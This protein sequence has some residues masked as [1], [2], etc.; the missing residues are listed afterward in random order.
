MRLPSLN[1]LR[2]FEA[3]ARHNGYIAAA[4]ELFVTR[5]AISR[6][7]KLLEEHLGVKLFRRNHKGVELTAAGRELLPVLTESFRAVARQCE[8]IS[9]NAS[10]LRIIC[11]PALSIR[12]LFPIL[13][14]FREMHPEIRVRLT[15]DFYGEKGFDTSEYDLGIS[16]ENLP[17]RSPNIVTHPL[18]PSILSPACAPSLLEGGKS[19]S[20]PE[21]IVNF[22][23]LHESPR[24]E[25][26]ATWAHVFD[27][28]EIDPSSGEAFPNLD[29]ATKAAVM[30]SGII[31]ADL[32]LCREEIEQGTLVLPLGHMKCEEPY[33][34]Y[35]LIGPRDR[36]NDPKVRR[37][38]DWVVG[39]V[40]AD[41]LKRTSEVK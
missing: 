30:G 1:A 35:S 28:K 8:S 26:W 5:G 11:P 23:L 18:F 34:Q 2:A 12:W 25:D 3:A 21:D 31:M 24:R 33:G 14:Q 22:K 13:E 40:N 37:F 10:E 9:S 16:V 19:I 27:V 29:M 7:V 15:T 6:H 20:A 41:A 32:A 38:R 17:G 36:W 4:D 39:K